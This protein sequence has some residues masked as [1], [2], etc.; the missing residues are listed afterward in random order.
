MNKLSGFILSVFVLVSC[1]DDYQ[2]KPKGYLSLTYPN[3]IYEPVDVDCAYRFEKNKI[4]IVQ[5]SKS[6]QPCW[7]NLEYPDLKGTL[8]LTY[9]PVKDNL[10]R[11]L[12]DAQRMPLEHTTKADQIEGSSYINE[13]QKVYGT[14]YE[15]KGDAASQAQFYVTDSV[16]H[17]LTG[18]IYF[19]TAPNYDSI[20]PAADYLKRDM[21]HLVE[22]LQWKRNI[23]EN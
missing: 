4:S 16:N 17:F 7:I 1:N 12:I 14:V 19:K 9:R 11:L 20:L 13:V 6:N 23:T 15:I 10:R 22:S 3:P 8:F 21:K 18:A 5:P 2:P